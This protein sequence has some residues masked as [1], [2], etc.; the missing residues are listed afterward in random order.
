MVKHVALCSRAAEACCCSCRFLALCMLQAT[1]SVAQDDWRR[2]ICHA[3]VSLGIVLYWPQLSFAIAAWTT[4]NKDL[5]DQ[6]THLKIHFVDTVSIALYCNMQRHGTGEDAPALMLFF[7]HAPAR[8]CRRALGSLAGAAGR[9][10][11][12]VF[13]RSIYWNSR[14]Q[15]CC[16]RA[17][18]TRRLAERRTRRL[19]STCTTADKHGTVGSSVLFLLHA[20]VIAL[21]C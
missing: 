1:T 14:I 3:P 19:S 16:A 15:L 5:F 17:I 4:D 13:D 20:V 2:A 9:H 10:S 21:I 18:R 7:M 6:G 11:W 12:P 8:V